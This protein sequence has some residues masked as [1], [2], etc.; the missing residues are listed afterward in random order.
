MSKE[1]PYRVGDEVVTEIHG[2]CGKPRIVL[3][4]SQ[5]AESSS[6]WTLCVSEELQPGEERARLED[7]K[8]DLRDL[9]AGWFKPV[10]KT[11][12]AI[13]KGSSKGGGRQKR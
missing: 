3:E 10:E 5:S 6:G 9:D 4:I 11:A 8:V 12:K 1:A 7:L 2:P 13:K